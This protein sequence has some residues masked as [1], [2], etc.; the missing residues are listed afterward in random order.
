MISNKIK[1]IVLCTR[2]S[3]A[4]QKKIITRGPISPTK[5]ALLNVF[6]KIISIIIIEQYLGQSKDK[7]Y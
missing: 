6:C 1:N 5:L 4:L 7:I 3:F 2:K